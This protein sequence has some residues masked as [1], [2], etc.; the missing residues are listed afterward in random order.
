VEK[1]Y[2]ETKVCGFISRNAKNIGAVT[3]NY[4]INV[5]NCRGYNGFD[6]FIMRDKDL[7]GLELKYLQLNV[8]INLRDGNDNYDSNALN[9]F[10]NYAPISVTS[11]QCTGVY[12]NGTTKRAQSYTNGIDNDFFAKVIDKNVVAFLFPISTGTDDTTNEIMDKI[13][14]TFHFVASSENNAKAAA[15]YL[16][17]REFAFQTAFKG[18]AVN[19][20]SD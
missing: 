8:T 3:L 14:L 13:A 4:Q 6:S 9:Q 10:L 20:F 17:G 18:L 11:P 19:E 12:Y 1:V 2:Y 5:D 16:E 15:A 7:D